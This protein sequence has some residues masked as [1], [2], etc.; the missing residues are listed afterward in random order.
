MP[1]I[2]QLPSKNREQFRKTRGQRQEEILK[3]AQV[4]EER[5]QLKRVSR[6]RRQLMLRPA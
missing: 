5:E 3:K 4:K 2:T 6:E 1:D